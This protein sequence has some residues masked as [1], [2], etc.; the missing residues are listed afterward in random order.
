[1]QRLIGTHPFGLLVIRGVDNIAANSVP[2]FLD[3]DPAGGPGTLLSHAARAN[4]LWHEALS[5]VDLLVVFQGA[6][7]D[8][9]LAW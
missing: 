9:S 3:A 5:D 1:L 6:Q 4:P 2:F 8:V 7:A